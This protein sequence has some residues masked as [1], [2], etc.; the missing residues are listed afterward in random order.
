MEHFL[1][2][3]RFRDLIAFVPWGAFIRN[4]NEGHF[5]VA[6]FLC[7]GG[8]EAVVTTNYDTH[9]EAGLQKLGEQD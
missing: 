4:P 3:N 2:I 1:R 8:F 9:I 5:A 7:C 6:D